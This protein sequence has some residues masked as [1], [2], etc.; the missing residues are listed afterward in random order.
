VRTLSPLLGQFKNSHEAWERRIQSGQA[1]TNMA[2]AIS[3]IGPD[4]PTDLFVDR[5]LSRRCH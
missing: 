5:P 3:R 4:K 1:T 2:I